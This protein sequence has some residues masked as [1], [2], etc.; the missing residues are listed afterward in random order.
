M[1][2]APNIQTPKS[3]KASIVIALLSMVVIIQS[4]KIFMDYGEKGEVNKQLVATTEDLTGTRQRL[5]EIS[6][7]L[8]QKIIE[9]KKIGGNVEDLKKAKVEIETQLK[10]NT[11]WSSKAIKELK[12]RVAGYEELLKAKDTQIEKYKSFFWTLIKHLTPDYFKIKLL[13]ILF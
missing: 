1:S 2:T 8:D 9:I 12:D 10:R 4:I 6:N 11:A 5:A 13:A 7:E 3:N